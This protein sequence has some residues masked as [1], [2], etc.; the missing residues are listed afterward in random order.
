MIRSITAIKIFVFYLATL[1][2]VTAS[3][4]NTPPTQEQ[5]RMLQQLPASQREEVLEALREGK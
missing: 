1:V 4:Q 2:A 3:G 5:M